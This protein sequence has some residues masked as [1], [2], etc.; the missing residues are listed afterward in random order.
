MPE[1]VSGQD[2]NSYLYAIL[3]LNFSQRIR[4]QREGCGHSVYAAVYVV[5]KGGQFVLLGRDCFSAVFGH[6][7]GLGRPKWMPNYSS[8]TGGRT[9]T[10]Q[11][12]E[13]LLENTAVFLQKLESEYV[14]EQEHE[15][16]RLQAAA[17]SRV[18]RERSI[19]AMKS[20]IAAFK[21][22][23][24]QPGQPHA[25]QAQ[26]WAPDRESNSTFFCY[27]LTDGTSWVLYLA[28]TQEYRIR[29]WP[30]RADGWER[31]WPPSVGTV[32]LDDGCYRVHDLAEALRHIRPLIY[33]QSEASSES[34]LVAVFG[35]A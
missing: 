16:I 19:A 24:A 2:H 4:C 31:Y 3:K 11:E 28:N 22:R 17:Q 5:R 23:N 27:R 30:N 1:I 10:E 35:S 14:Q 34:S 26:R 7:W 18:E 15:R 29:A 8:S 21:Q 13:M 32:E 6:E 33:K 20:K 25:I 9:L 12:R